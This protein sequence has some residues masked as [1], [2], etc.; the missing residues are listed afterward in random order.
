[1]QLQK[2]QSQK[3]L[4]IERDK[5]IDEKEKK[6]SQVVVLE[7]SIYQKRRTNE[8]SGKFEKIELES[9]KVTGTQP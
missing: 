5:G 9:T 3:R 8:S 7:K 4:S 2:L 6:T 1:V